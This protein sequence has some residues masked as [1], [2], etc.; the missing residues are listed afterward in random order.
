MTQRRIN[1]RDIIVQVEDS[2]P[3]SWL[4]IE[5][6]ASATFNRGENEETADTT[7]FESE[8]AYEQEV[9]QRGASMSLAGQELRDDTTGELQPGRARVEEMAGEDKVGAASLGRIRFRHPTQTVW[10]IWKCT[11]SLG[12]NGGDT[13]AKSGWAAT[14]TKSGLSSTAPVT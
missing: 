13:N 2:T 6:L 3:D 1:A 8:G 14:I 7:D 4:A 10:R 9:M 12:E 11:F 5:N